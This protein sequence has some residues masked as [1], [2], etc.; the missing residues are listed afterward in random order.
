MILS[1]PD[2][3]EK[4]VPELSRNPIIRE[5]A[6]CLVKMFNASKSKVDRAIEESPE[7]SS[8]FEDFKKQIVDEFRKELHY[9][10]RC[11]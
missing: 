5:T 9:R 1:S 6:R 2:I 8:D 3:E 10:I 4:V 7:P 11:T